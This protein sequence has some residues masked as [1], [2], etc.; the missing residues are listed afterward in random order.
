MKKYMRKLLRQVGASEEG[1]TIVYFALALPVFFGFAGL[2]FDASLWFMER[3]ML[4][5]TAD[6]AV[7]SAA[8]SKFNGGDISD[9]TAAANYD[10]GVNGFTVGGGSIMTVNSPPISGAFAGS[11]NYVQVIAT[12]PADGFFSAVLG[13]SGVN[14]VTAATAGITTIGGGCLVA[15]HP[16]AD[17]AIS[18]SGS[19]TINLDCGISSNSDSDQSIYLNG[20]VTVSAQPA[21][22]ADGDIY[23][24]GSSTLDP[25]TALRPDSGDSSDPF[26]DL[27]IPGMNGVASDPA[28]EDTCSAEKTDY[29][30]PNNA[31]DQADDPFYDSGTD[32]YV[33]TPGRYC[34]GL[35]LTMNSATK[36]SVSF[37][38]GIYIM[39]AGDFD[40]GAQ[41]IVS[42]D[43]VT[44]I[45]T[46]D[47]PANIGNMDVN[48]GAAIDMSAPT[49]DDLATASPI[50]QEYA[51]VLVYQDRRADYDD[52]SN[53]L[54]GNNNMTFSGAIYFPSQE[55]VYNGT[56]GSTGGCT[57]IIAATVKING[58]ND[59]AIVNNN[60]A[61]L[62]MGINT[63][64]VT[65]VTLV[66]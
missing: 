23:Q 39:D 29:S 41:A 13:V 22:T 54:N 10:A 11:S 43:G 1:V 37:E 63:T 15:L 27:E 38:P 8:H 25:A 32:T 57:Q 2:A 9:M 62:A 47:D 6:A 40:I 45:L 61:C 51:G 42:G 65:L 26:S 58:N 30:F 4:Q 33:L 36:G 17:Q 12:E 14:V 19:A 60:A 20:N 24:G 3:R 55:L 16:T 52:S 53:S 64:E 49:V 59:T 46:A 18:L 21:L 66:E 5:N 31:T 48:G 50:I 44:I 28:V 35:A 56:S 34:G 7:M